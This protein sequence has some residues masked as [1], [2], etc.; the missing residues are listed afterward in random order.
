MADI[1]PQQ[2]NHLPRNLFPRSTA[3]SQ[4]NHHVLHNVGVSLVRLDNL[5]F[6]SAYVSVRDVL[7]IPLAASGGQLEGRWEDV[8]P[9]SAVENDVMQDTLQ[10]PPHVNV[11]NYEI[12]GYPELPDVSEV[13]T[14]GLSSSCADTPPVTPVSI[15]I[16]Q[17][18]TWLRCS[19]TRKRR[20]SRVY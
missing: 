5:P 11:A 20:F 18:R 16:F 7:Q 14:R 8:L 9:A 12:A 6:A 1:D 3:R 17:C 10:V 19:R 15:H 2:A 4:H 13:Y